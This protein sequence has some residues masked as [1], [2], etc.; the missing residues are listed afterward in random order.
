MKTPGRPSTTAP[1]T[2]CRRCRSSTAG[3]ARLRS[4]ATAIRCTRTSRSRSLTGETEHVAHA[5][6][7]D[8]GT[9]WLRVGDALPSLNSD[10]VAER[11]GVGARRGDDRGRALDAVLH[12]ARGG[13]GR[14]DVHLSRARGRPARA[15]RRRFRR[16][17]SNVPTP[18]C[19]RSTRIRCAMRMATG[20]CSRASTSRTASTRSRSAA[21]RP[22]PAFRA[23]QRL[24]DAD[25]DHARAAGRSR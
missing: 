5:R 14:Q 25:E 22:R 12:G 6:S 17:R 7:D 8:G 18:R 21:R 13:H 4:F 11:R 1:S 15:V 3:S 2:R 24:G 23:R 9:T 16:G 10:A 20:T 19:G